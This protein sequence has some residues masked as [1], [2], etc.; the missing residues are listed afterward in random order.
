MLKNKTEN[1][2]SIKYNSVVINVDKG[3]SLDVRDFGIPN[4][5]VA[6][7]EK[8]LM[9]KYAGQFEQVKGITKFKDAEGYVAQIDELENKVEKLSKE[10][11]KSQEVCKESS[12][13]FSTAQEGLN[14]AVKR[15][16]S[17][18][19]EIQKLKDENNELEEEIERQ[20]T[21]VSGQKSGKSKK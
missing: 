20:K 13:K 10:L 8:H 21:I 9:I 19:S 1:P 12:A 6:G 11:S 4:D 2:V 18:K 15:E 14:E 17:F 16:S 5:A 3:E 7:T